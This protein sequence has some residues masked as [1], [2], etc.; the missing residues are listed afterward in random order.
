MFLTLVSGVSPWSLPPQA[1]RLVTEELIE[2]AIASRYQSH[3]KDNA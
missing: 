3:R 1:Q 2:Y